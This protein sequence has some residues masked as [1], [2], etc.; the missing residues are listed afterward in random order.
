MRE[1]GPGSWCAPSRLLKYTGLTFDPE[2]RKFTSYGKGPQLVTRMSATV[3]APQ[4]AGMR[5]VLRDFAMKPLAEGSDGADGVLAIP[6]EL[7]VFSVDLSR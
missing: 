1:A 5:Y 3:T 4:I 6:S 7:A 2:Q